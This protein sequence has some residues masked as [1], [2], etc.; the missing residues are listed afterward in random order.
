MINRNIFFIFNINASLFFKLTFFLFETMLI[1]I[2]IIVNYFLDLKVYTRVEISTLINSKI[3]LKIK[4][5][6]ECLFILYSLFSAYISIQC[7]NSGNTWI[8][9][10]KSVK[11][12]DLK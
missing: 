1:I 12:N 11:I 8:K 9:I 5:G 4:L 10:I 6:Y 2:K 3:Y 7:T